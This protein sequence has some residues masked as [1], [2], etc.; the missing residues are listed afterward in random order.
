MFRTNTKLFSF[1]SLFSSFLSSFRSPALSLVVALVAFSPVSVAAKASEGWMGMGSK[2]PLIRLAVTPV[3]IR[4]EAPTP[5]TGNNLQLLLALSGSNGGL[6]EIRKKASQEFS[7]YL[8][9]QV[10]MRFGEFFADERVHLVDA[11]APLTLHTNFDISI[12]QKI[13]DIFSGE[14]YDLEK[15]TMSAYGKFHYRLQGATRAFTLREGTVD[16]SKLKLS[17]RYRTRAPKDGGVVEDTT[18]EATEELLAEIAEEVLD[19]VEDDLEAD[20]LLKLARR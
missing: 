13:L 1:S 11:R 20:V 3:E 8:D 12:R 6:G 5:L 7:Q 17:A 2:D 15:G 18:R 10:Q 4:I 16:I 9:Q 19:R 14:D